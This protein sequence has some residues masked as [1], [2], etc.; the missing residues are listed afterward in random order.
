M[1]ESSGLAYHFDFSF[2]FSANFKVLSWLGV[3]F[4]L[5]LVPD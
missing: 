1:V 3:V 2:E 4:G 5:G